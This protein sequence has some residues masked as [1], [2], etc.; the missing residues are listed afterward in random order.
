MSVF[1]SDNR[2][3]GNVVL[4]FLLLALIGYLLPWVRATNAAMTLNAFDLA[5]WTSL[6]PLQKG[7]TP[8]LVVPLLLRM[9]L[10]VLAVSIALWPTSRKAIYLASVVIVTLSI[11]QLPP[12]EFLDNRDDANY[13]QLLILALATPVLSIVARRFLP[14]RFR[15]LVTSVLALA[16]IVTSLAGQSQALELYRVTLEKGETGGGLG[17]MV[18]AYVAIS[19]NALRYRH[20]R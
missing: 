4:V 5:E 14:A 7:A 13:R 11:S 6:H 20:R 19:L 8:A 2:K 17:L 10:L 16:G 12:F 3:F 15:P 9:Q 1:S 18:V